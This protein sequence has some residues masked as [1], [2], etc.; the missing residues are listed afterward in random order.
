[1]KN[2]RRNFLKKSAAVGAGFFIVPRNVLG[3]NGFI[4][5][6]DQLNI[7]AIGAGGKGNDITDSWASGERVIALCDVH[8]DGQHGVT[9]S[10][11]TYPKANFYVDFREM[12]DKEKDLDAVTI[13]T[14]DH[15]HAVI[16]INAMNRGLHVYVQ[17]PLTHNIEEAR[18][19]TQIAAKNKVVTQMGNQGGSSSGVVKI[20][21]WVDKKMIGKINK[22]YAWTNRPVWP[23]GFDMKD[24][25]EVKPPNLNWDLWLGPAASSKYTSQLHPFNWRGW[26]DYGTG[27]LGD[28]A[29]H[30]LDAP[31]KTL[32]LHYPTDVECS[33][34]QVFEQAWSQNFVP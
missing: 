14:P 5:P 15:T 26:W 21:E 6:S 2:K 19:L 1:M 34:G 28:M 23:Q 18:V 22:I 3:G 10:R 7:A 16:A 20:Q 33:V 13:S 9:D 8:P 12:L 31:Y 17:K 11:K 30:I 25:N 24:N 27:A 4:S 32:G 29:C